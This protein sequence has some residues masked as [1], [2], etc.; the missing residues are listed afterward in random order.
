MAKVDLGIL[1]RDEL[2]EAY[3]DLHKRHR[4][5]FWRHKTAIGFFNDTGIAEYFSL[6]VELKS[7]GLDADS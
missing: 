7:R 6:W 1:T 5:L 3:Q 4:Q 2:E